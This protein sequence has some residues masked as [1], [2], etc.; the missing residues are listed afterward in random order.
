MRLAIRPKLV[1]ATMALPCLFCAGCLGGYVYPTATYIPRVPVG[2]PA[3]DEV[4]AF[5]FDIIDYTGSIDL[6]GSDEYLLR[7]LPM[8]V[9]GDVLPQFTIGCGRGW[10]GVYHTLG[11]AQRRHPTLRVRLY[12]PGYET[13]QVGPWEWRRALKCQPATT[14]D[15]QDK[16]LD[17]LISTN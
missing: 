11:Y 6:A 3:A 17:Y 5:R 1:T 13:V 9:R 4:H 7:E 14:L 10:W 15:A 16:T 8:T 2:K 12:R